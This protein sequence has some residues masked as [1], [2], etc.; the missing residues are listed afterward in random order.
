MERRG[1]SFREWRLPAHTRQAAGDCRVRHRWCSGA[2]SV[3]VAGVAVMVSALH[4]LQP[5]RRD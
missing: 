4:P 1:G 2:V 3:T 5:G